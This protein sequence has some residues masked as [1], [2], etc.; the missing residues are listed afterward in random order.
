MLISAFSS[1]SLIQRSSSGPRTAPAPLGP[2]EPRP[3]VLTR[4]SQ[5][6][7]QLSLFGPPGGR[8]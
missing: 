5:V 4:P 6:L 1:A 2:I 8:R 3:Q 7:Q